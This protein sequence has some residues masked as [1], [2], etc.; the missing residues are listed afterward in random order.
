MSMIFGGSLG[1]RWSALVV[2]LSGRWAATLN[3]TIQSQVSSVGKAQAMNRAW[4]K[5]PQ[6]DAEIVAEIVSSAW[7]A[8]LA[9]V[10]D[11]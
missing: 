9:E 5:W 10:S 2:L 11:A 7:D 1:A 3:W 4:E 8:A 6:V